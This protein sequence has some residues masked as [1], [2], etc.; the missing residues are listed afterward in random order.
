MECNFNIHNAISEKDKDLTPVLEEAAGLTS[1]SF[2][3]IERNDLDTGNKSDA[4]SDSDSDSTDDAYLSFDSDQEDGDQEKDLAER[5]AREHERQLVLEA[6][7]LIL[8]QDE[9]KVPPPRP[10]ARSKSKRTRRP[11]PA[12]PDHK[13]SDSHKDLPV[14]PEGDTSSLA[15]ERL[16][17]AFERYEAF[18]RE[19]GDSEI[20]K[21]L[22]VV[23]TLSGDWTSPPS[24]TVSSM[25]RED[26]GQGSRY[27]SLMQ[28]LGRSKTPTS[29]DEKPKLVISA[30]ILAAPSTSNEANSPAR[31][32]SPAFG[33]VRFF[34][35]IHPLLFH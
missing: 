30:P 19:Q 13:R 16:D 4:S 27:T 18:K 22:S 34:S 17:D 9:N 15:S 11:P 24:P 3:P 8:K 7:G 29:Q 10:L 33:T 20:N 31:A 5:K 25:S 26:S 2:P 1:E 35:F 6:A 28:F 14:V 23:S 32:N 12:A 21:R